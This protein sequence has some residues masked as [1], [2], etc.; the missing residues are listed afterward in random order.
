[1]KES[2][3]KEIIRAPDSPASFKPPR[4]RAKK[5]APNIEA[6][7]NLRS[8]LKASSG[9]ENVIDKE[10]PIQPLK[11]RVVFDLAPNI[12]EVRSYKRYNMIT[13]GMES[14]RCCKCAIF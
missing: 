2:Q 12:I 3:Y 13:M 4:K 6:H 5:S 7:M 14:E 1:M 10:A 9:K 8:I 11:K